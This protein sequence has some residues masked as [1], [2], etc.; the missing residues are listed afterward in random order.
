ML[1]AHKEAHMSKDPVETLA[2][3]EAKVDIIDERQRGQAEL[4][5]AQAEQ[6]RFVLE[7]TQAILRLLEPKP[8]DGPS[9]DELL[10]HIVGQLTEVTGH[11]REQIRIVT[12]MEGS[13]PG[14]VARSL[15]S[16]AAPGTS[17]A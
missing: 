14:D 8:Q 12:R 2:R 11:T 17:Q 7:G 4:Q 16:P 15:V 6:G 9:L 3:L 5:E 10:G 1:T 13:L